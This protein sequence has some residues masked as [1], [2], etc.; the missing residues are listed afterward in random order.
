MRATSIPKNLRI[1]EYELEDA[2]NAIGLAIKLAKQRR[3]SA[4]VTSE[5]IAELGR[6]A[7]KAVKALSDYISE[8][9]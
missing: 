7:Q 2:T 9:P 8:R 1:P 4:G 5:R 6:E 3:H